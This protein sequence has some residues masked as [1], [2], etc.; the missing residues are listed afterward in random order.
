VGIGYKHIGTSPFGTD[1]CVIYLQFAAWAVQ[2][3]FPESAP[4]IIGDLSSEGGGHLD[5]HRSHQSGRD[6]DV[7]WYRSDNKALRWFKELPG[8][9]LDVEKS[10][11]FIEALLRTNAVKYI[12]IDRAIQ[13]RLYRQAIQYGWSDLSLQRVFQYPSGQRRTL[14]RHEPGHKNHFHVRFKCSRDDSDCVP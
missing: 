4:I 3:M 5:P 13:E 9:Q 10:W 2:A 6:S 14:V 1:E 12:F 11:V 7:G 8:D